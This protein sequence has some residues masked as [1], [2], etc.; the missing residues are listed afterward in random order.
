[1]TG[2]AA[3]KKEK[4]KT[5][6]NLFSKQEEERIVDELVLSLEKEKY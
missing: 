1:L 4:R 3:L 6:Y 2:H 5:Y